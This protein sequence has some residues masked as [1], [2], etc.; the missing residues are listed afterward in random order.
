MKQFAVLLMAVLFAGTVYSGD[1]HHKIEIKVV[2]DDGNGETSVVIDS[3]DLLADPPA[4]ISAYCQAIG[5]PFVA[6][7]LSWE[8][9]KRDEVLWYDGND[10]IWH[11]SLRDSDGLKAQDPKPAN[12]DVLPDS[13]R[14]HYDKFMK[15]Y[16]ALYAHRMTISAD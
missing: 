1:K 14:R 16:G 13:L 7:A 2:T 8:P 5:I 11:A 12:L 10:N 6:E 4:M 9:G 3:D 15:L